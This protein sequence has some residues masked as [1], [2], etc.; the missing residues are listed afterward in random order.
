M[1]TAIMKTRLLTLP[2]LS[3][4]FLINSSYPQ[5]QQDWVAI[6]NGPENNNDVATAIVVDNSGNVYVTGHNN[7]VGDYA[8]IKY[9]SSGVQQWVAVYNGPANAQDEAYSIAVDALGTVYVTGWSTGS[10]TSSDYATIKYNS[11]GVQQWV[12][13]YNGP[14]NSSDAASSIALDGSGN[15][16]VTGY[17]RAGSGFGTEDYA[18]I[19]YNSSGVQQWVAR[20]N[21]PG[22]FDDEAT[23]ITVDG[24][25]NVYVTGYSWGSLEDYATI[26]YNSSGVQQWVQRYDG[27]PHL[28]DHAHSIEVDVSNVYVTGYSS[29]SG[30]DYDYAT[31]KYNSSGVQQWV[32]RY[33]GPG[34]GLDEAFSF[35]VDGSGNVYVTGGSEGSGTGPDYATIKYNSSGVQQ[36]IAIYN[37]PGND[38]DVAYSIA[39]DGSSNVYVTGYSWASGTGDDY[40]T[41]KYNSTGVQ[42]WFQRYNRTEISWD[43]AHS[44]GVDALGNVYVTGFSQGGVT[45]NDYATIK[46]SQPIGIT[47]LSNQIPERFRLYQN[48]PNP[49]NPVIKIKFDIPAVET[50]SNTSLRIYDILGREVTALVNEELKPGTYEVEWDA[51]N[52]PSGMYFYR[53]T[54]GDFTQTNKMI[55]MK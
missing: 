32:Q 36:W 50:H 45:G 49:F 16:Y 12:Q 23:S 51:A 41:I 31:I 21:G 15:V 19:K 4:L 54:A 43:E 47:P 55:L 37:G 20:Y 33:N 24:S 52:S 1:T 34:N 10:G 8:T 48:Y 5:V 17:S 22:N 28:S 44:I 40:A 13:R 30:T 2:L 46:Y 6:Y 26:K 11:S 9:N 7:G 42:Q 53:L 27:P 29:G 3:I 18:T 39:I 35:A 38:V 14:G 25:G